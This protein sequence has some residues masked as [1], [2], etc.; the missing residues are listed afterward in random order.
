MYR[1]E[2]DRREEAEESLAIIR[3]NGTRVIGNAESWSGVV[4]T[5]F[6]VHIII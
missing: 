6:N 2:D 5:Q 4:V 1:T 3:T